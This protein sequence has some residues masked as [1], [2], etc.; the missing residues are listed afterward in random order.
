ME[1]Q[2]RNVNCLHDSHSQLA[3]ILLISKDFPIESPFRYGGHMLMFRSLTERKQK[4][5]VEYER[6]TQVLLCDTIEPII[7]FINHYT[8]I[9]IE[10]EN[11]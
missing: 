3:K 7:V 1:I 5:F 6:S 8:D 10:T 4:L 11:T 9:E 2:C